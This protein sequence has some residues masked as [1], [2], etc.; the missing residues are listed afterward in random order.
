MRG[1][2]T[3]AWILSRDFG[4]NDAQVD[5]IA[6][7]VAMAAILRD[8]GRYAQD[9]MRNV[10]RLFCSPIDGRQMATLFSDSAR[11]QWTIGIVNAI[12]GFWWFLIFPLGLVI[13]RV[14]RH[15]IKT[16]WALSL[17]LTEAY[18]LGLPVLT[19]VTYGRFVLPLLPVLAEIYATAD[20]AQKPPAEKT[21]YKFL[22]LPGFWWMGNVNSRRGYVSP[23]RAHGDNA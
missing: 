16:R 22:V 4:L 5:Q 6:R 14:P 19:T 11:L 21:T 8:P 10:G 3:A 2:Y 18:L 23:T 20:R 12:W 17:L 13:F 15:L 7:K 1:P 9:I